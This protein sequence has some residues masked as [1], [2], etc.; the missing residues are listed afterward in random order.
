M[1]TLPGCFPDHPKLPSSCWLYS[2][3]SKNLQRS[4]SELAVI[5]RHANHSLDLPSNSLRNRWACANESRTCGLCEFPSRAAST[6]SPPHRHHHIG[7]FDRTRLR[8][9]LPL[10]LPPSVLLLSFKNLRYEVF[11]GLIEK[12]TPRLRCLLCNLC[13]D[14][15]L[16]TSCWTPNFRVANKLDSIAQQFIARIT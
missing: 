10:G 8:W 14:Q 16:S 15:N 7:L 4:A 13:C 3:R 11:L 6:S 12:P 9:K 5:L 2:N 1:Y